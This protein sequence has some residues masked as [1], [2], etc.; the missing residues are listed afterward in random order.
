MIGDTWSKQRFYWSG[1]YWNLWS[2]WIWRRLPGTTSSWI[3]KP[4][5]IFLSLYCAA[6]AQQVG[7]IAYMIVSFLVIIMLQ[8][9]NVHGFWYLYTECERSLG[10]IVFVVDV[11]P[12]KD[13]P[14]YEV[15]DQFKQKMKF[16][17]DVVGSLKYGVESVRV[18]VCFLS[19]TQVKQKSFKTW[20]N[21]FFQITDQNDW[22]GSLITNFN[23][24]GIFLKLT[25]ITNC[26]SDHL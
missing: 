6:K 15:R 7:C 1:E 16:I 26:Q 18:A 8:L 2:D 14:A 5:T 13:L 24:L 21:F 17:A 11:N 12:N 3:Q 20:A 22:S 25:Q 23:V 19:Y 10:D 9:I 4:L